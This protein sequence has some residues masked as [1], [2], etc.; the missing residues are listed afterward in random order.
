MRLH[1][2]LIAAEYSLVGGRRMHFWFPAFSASYG[3][4]SPGVL[5]TLQTLRLAAADS[6]LSAD[7]GLDGEPYKKHFAQPTDPVFEGVVPT[8]GP[9]LDLTAYLPPRLADRMSRLKRKVSRRWGTIRACEPDW[10]GV[11][12]GAVKAVADASLRGLLT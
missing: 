4:Y 12:Y 5:L 8:P 7:F 10:P 1:D 11:A 3:R 9:F 6:L 2:E